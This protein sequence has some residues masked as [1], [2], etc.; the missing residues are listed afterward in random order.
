M[1][2]H[3]P[4]LL[5]VPVLF[6]VAAVLGVVLRTAIGGLRRAK[7]EGYLVRGPGSRAA[8]EPETV[9]G[10]AVAIAS[11]VMALLAVLA[12]LVHILR[13]IAL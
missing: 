3:L 9:L 11:V 2:S 4:T 10:W 12:L 13:Q 1:R 8:F 7:R 6:I 5:A